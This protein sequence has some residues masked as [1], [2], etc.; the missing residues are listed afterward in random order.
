MHNGK[1]E[2]ISD[3]DGTFYPIDNLLTS[4]IDQSVE[5]FL[6]SHASINKEE[7]REL[8]KS[9]PNVLDALGILNISREKFYKKVYSHLEYENCINKN[10]DLI[11]VLKNSNFN[12][13]IV[14]LSPRKHIE[15]ILEIMQLSPFIKDIC[16]LEHE[17]NT[18]K[19]N[20]YSKIIK[21]MGLPAKDIWVVG[22]NYEIDI[23]PA[24]KLG[25]QTALIKKYSI[26]GIPA[27]AT[28]VD[29]LDRKKGNL[30]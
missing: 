14:S 8:E 21:K 22:D 10:P 20:V 13:T 1:I 27:F 24:V 4:Q 2:I 29:F 3:L 25:C 11:Y 28:I 6:L 30:L 16:S 7:L 18:C 12:I 23:V 5:T 9:H 26:A 17:Q 19:E 15:R